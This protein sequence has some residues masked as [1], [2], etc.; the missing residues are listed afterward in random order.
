MRLH[1]I[2]AGLAGLSAALS[3]SRAGAQVTL[4]EASPQAGGR[5]RSFR[6]E[7][8]G[9]VIDNGGHV[10]LG[11]NAATLAFLDAVGGRA[12]MREVAPA[13]IPFM[14]LAN[15]ETWVLR[16][17]RGPIPW[18]AL[19]PSRR[20][21]RTRPRDYLGALRLLCAS[22]DRTVGDTLGRDDRL[23]A[24]LWEPLCTAI[25]NTPT[26]RAAARP[27]S[28]VV[29]ATLL[30]GEAA[31]RALVAAHGLSAA[32]ADPALRRLDDLNSAFRP[33]WRLTRISPDH[34][35]VSKLMF[36]DR[37]V[38]LGPDDAVIVAVPA[39][40]AAELLPDLTV[41][42]DFEAIVNAH[43]RLSSPARLP[44]DLPLLGLIGGTAQWLI[45]RDDIVSVTVSAAGGLADEP[46]ESLTRRLWSDV[47]RAL[48][49][50]DQPVPPARLIKERRATI[51][52]TPTAERLRPQPA[53]K[54]R[55]L[56][57]AGDW[58]ATGWPAT[59]EGAILSGARAWAALRQ[60]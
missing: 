56:A 6:D 1:V 41:P 32:F 37:E 45:T 11:A 22:S 46:V 53:T 31:C 9:T 14:D 5:C 10:V 13:A 57:L 17:N 12:A 25:M 30:S 8:L 40:V 51:S 27:F 48:G 60:A 21:P 54:W 28:R 47:A 35:R 16:P 52:Q 42:N 15:G 50:P 44:G 23:V 58:V 2:G 20:V 36:V 49:R 55:N 7:T 43:F 3:A 18:W 26:A 4:Y 29:R 38:A 33:G 24:R 34:D 19:A 39:A 59:I